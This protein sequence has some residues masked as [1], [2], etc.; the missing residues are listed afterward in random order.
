[1]GSV[2]KEEMAVGATCVLGENWLKAVKGGL[3][4]S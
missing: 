4:G 2:V 1:M 3:G